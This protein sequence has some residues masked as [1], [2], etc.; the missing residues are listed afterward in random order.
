MNR[1]AGMQ[2]TKSEGDESFVNETC[3]TRVEVSPNAPWT[4]GRALCVM[5]RKRVLL[6]VDTDAGDAFRHW[7]EQ[8]HDVGGSLRR[9][10]WLTWRG[11]LHFKFLPVLRKS[12]ELILL[13]WKAGHALFGILPKEVIVRKIFPKVRGLALLQHVR[14]GCVRVEN[15]DHD[16]TVQEHGLTALFAYWR[17][18]VE[19]H[20]WSGCEFAEMGVSVCGE[21]EESSVCCDNA[22]C[23]ACRTFRIT[24][25]RC[26][27]Y[28]V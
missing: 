8:L 1:E 10:E 9:L 17:K 3:M 28:S 23:V 2:E 16:I 24:A 13:A 21:P 26:G 6:V 11:S 5:T 12:L 25:A 20:G 22:E 19:Q 27:V 4:I 7:I 14:Y 15:S 18:S